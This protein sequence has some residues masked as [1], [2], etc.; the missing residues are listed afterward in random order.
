MR[1]RQHAKCRSVCCS[2][3]VLRQ[4]QSLHP[5]VTFLQGTSLR[6]VHS[7]TPGAS[8]TLRCLQCALACT[9]QRPQSLVAPRL[10][11]VL[12]PEEWSVI[13]NPYAFHLGLVYAGVH[14]PRRVLAASRPAKL[15]QH[16]AQLP[17][18]CSVESEPNPSCQRATS[19][20]ALPALAR[21]RLPWVPA[22]CIGGCFLCV[23]LR[24]QCVDLL[25]RQHLQPYGSACSSIS[26]FHH[27]HD[28]SAQPRIPARHE[29]SYRTRVYAVF[30]AYGR[31]M[32]LERMMHGQSSS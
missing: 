19:A 28:A 6:D 23:Q 18:S 15:V 2:T 20:A 24:N 3:D 12:W 21:R 8:P 13:N 26:T 29:T 4:S 17:L 30:R 27:C 9:C 10:H 1:K 25:V 5:R 31:E 11:G 16:I 7:G 32:V 14:N 22:C